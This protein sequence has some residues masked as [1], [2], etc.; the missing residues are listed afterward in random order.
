MSLLSN[1]RAKLDAI[2]ADLA[3]A[4]HKYVM[5]GDLEY[6]M[7]RVAE[8]QYGPYTGTGANIDVEVNGDPKLVIL[9][10]QTQ[11]CLGVHIRGMDAASYFEI[12]N[13][14]VAYVGAAGITVGTDTFRIGT[15]GNINTGADVGFWLTLS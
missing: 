5:V 2:G 10:D 4:I 15:D 6:A 12:D 9:F 1:L 14:A 7:A 13:G 3:L 8:V 11:Q